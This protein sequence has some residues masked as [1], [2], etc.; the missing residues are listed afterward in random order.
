MRNLRAFAVFVV[1]CAI[2]AGIAWTG[3]FD[4]DQRNW[5]VAMWTGIVILCAA[6]AAG[7]SRE[8]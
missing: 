6:I 1:G 2:G 5:L 3:G 8:L 4:F 7:A